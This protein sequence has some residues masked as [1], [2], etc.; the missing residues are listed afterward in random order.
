VAMVQ[1][2][3]ATDNERVVAAAYP[4]VLAWCALQLDTI[5]ERRRR[6]AG[7]AILLAQI[8][9]LLVMGRVWPVP[10]PED[11]LPH[12][13]PIRYVEIAIVL[14]SAAAAAVAVTKRPRMTAVP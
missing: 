7:L 1:L 4:F 9:W 10:L 8:P 2:L 5:D 14:G 6:W 12:F 13:P 3:V 11:Q